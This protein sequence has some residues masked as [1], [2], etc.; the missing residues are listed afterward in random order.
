MAAAGQR[1]NRSRRTLSNHRLR[2]LDPQRLHQSDGFDPLALRLV[3][4]PFVAW[5]RRCPPFDRNSQATCC[6]SWFWFSVSM[7]GSFYFLWAV[8]FWTDWHWL[9]SLGRIFHH[10]SL[11]PHLNKQKKLW[12]KMFTA[13]FTHSTI[14][15]RIPYLHKRNIPTPYKSGR[16]LTRCASA[17][18]LVS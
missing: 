7:Y 9:P 16:L 15:S 4:G 8:C 17:I 3:C 2:R 1:R 13:F 10:L 6:W 5:P 11:F 18:N 12:T 14:A